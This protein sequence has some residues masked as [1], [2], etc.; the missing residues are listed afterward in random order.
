MP[1][2]ATDTTT[3]PATGEAPETAPD[4]CD[5][6][7]HLLSAHDAVATRFCNATLHGALARGCLCR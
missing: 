1:A 2:P 7:G 5:V 4:K 3:P 6:C